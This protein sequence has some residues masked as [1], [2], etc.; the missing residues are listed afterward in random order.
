MSQAPLE[1]REISAPRVG[2]FK[3]YIQGD[4]KHS[5]FI[6]LTVH[7]L[8]CNHSMWTNFLAHPSMEEINR[9]GAFIH[10]DIPGQEDEAPD[11]P[12]DYTFPSMQ[13]LGE[14]L[15]CVLDQLD[16]KQVICVGEGAGAN[17]IARFAMAQPDR[18]LGCVLIHCTGTTA[19]VMESLKDKVM[20][21]K[22]EQI[23]MNPSTEAYLCLHRFGSV[24]KSLRKNR[25]LKKL[26]SSALNLAS[27]E[28][29]NY[30]EKAEN[31][32]QL[33]KVIE[34]FQESLRS[35]INPRNLKRF[36]QAFMRRSNIADQVGKL[37]CRVMMVTGSKAS[38]NHT[39]HNL[40][41]RM[42]ER[43]D[44]K[45]CDILEVD[46]VANVLE[47]KPERFA[48]SLL[49][50]LQGMGLVGGVPMPRVQRS[51]SIDST[52]TPPSRT[53][54][55]SMEEADMPRG[56]YSMSPPKYGS[57]PTRGS[58]GDVLSTSPTM[59]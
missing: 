21:W 7:D 9:R 26:L 58:S 51:A 56:I 46:G 30:F 52:G 15:V 54:S 20:N 14:D 6:I 32:E 41:A 5:Q 34:N 55:M 12:A 36:V 27:N 53:R 25:R 59:G 2:R 33:Q 10:V 24:G 28:A 8:G 16:V 31:K 22:L 29:F 44:K 18:V 39:V 49:Y 19:G 42:R 35:K 11:L 3:I 23:G 45:E 17:I 13:S 4:L 50:F 43:L 48:E 37:K 1:P 38:F 47:E 57:S 40:F